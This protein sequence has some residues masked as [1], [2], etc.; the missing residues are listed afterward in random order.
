MTYLACYQTNDE[1][2]HILHYFAFRIIYLSIMISVDDDEF[3][4][5]AV[6]YFY[7]KSINAKIH[8]RTKS[9]FL[10]GM[11]SGVPGLRV[12]SWEKIRTWSDDNRG[13]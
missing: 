13:R 1:N 7:M 6:C 11:F 9:T 4:L 5:R 3:H 10:Y 2:T 12:S 8:D